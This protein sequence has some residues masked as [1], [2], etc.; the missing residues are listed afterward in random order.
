MV[1]RVRSQLVTQKL[2][3]DALRAMTMIHIACASRVSF[4][5]DMEVIC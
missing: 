3:A 2:V 4:R 5:Q 1:E